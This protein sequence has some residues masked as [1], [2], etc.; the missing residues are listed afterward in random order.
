MYFVQG[1]RIA[2]RYIV[3]SPLAELSLFA[4]SGDFFHFDAMDFG[5]VFARF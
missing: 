2:N 1:T 5:L 4:G 3:S